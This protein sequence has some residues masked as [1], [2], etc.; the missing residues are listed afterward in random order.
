MPNHS[1]WDDPESPHYYEQPGRTIDLPV[2]I[3]PLLVRGGLPGQRGKYDDVEARHDNLLG[4]C[5]S[6]PDT[7]LVCGRYAALSA[8]GA[9]A[10]CVRSQAKAEREAAARNETVGRVKAVTR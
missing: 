3:K 2:L 4:S 10:F 9:C 1:S 8:T 6:M 5:R 7:C